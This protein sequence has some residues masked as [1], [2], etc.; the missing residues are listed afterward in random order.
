MSNATYFMLFIK[1]N[2]IRSILNVKF[3]EIVFISVS[4]SPEVRK[5]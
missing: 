1:W 3:T 5:G 4:D 2:E